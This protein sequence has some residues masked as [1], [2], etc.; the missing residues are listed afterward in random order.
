R[1]RHCCLP[2]YLR[3]Q[4]LQTARPLPTVSR[5]TVPPPSTVWNSILSAASASG[6]ICSVLAASEEAVEKP[7]SQ[8]LAQRRK[9]STLYPK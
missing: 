4:G 7:A 9:A 5:Y 3:D 6:R 8:T 2:S 1:W